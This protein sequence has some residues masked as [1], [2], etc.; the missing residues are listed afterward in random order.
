MSRGTLLGQLSSYLLFSF[1]Y[2]EAD[3]EEAPLVKV[4]F[5]FLK[6]SRFDAEC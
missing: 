5:G 2:D 4:C 1:D 3:Y 6:R